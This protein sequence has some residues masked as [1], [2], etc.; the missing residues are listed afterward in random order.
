MLW[1]KA[2]RESRWRFLSGFMLLMLLACGIVLEY[3]ATAR[4]MPLASSIDPGDGFLGRAIKEALEAQRDFRG[5][6]WWQWVRQNLAVTWTLFALLLGSGGLLTEPGGRGPWFTLSLPAS[7]DRLLAVR[8]GAGLA[9]L[10]VLALVPSLLIPLMSPAIGETYPLRLAIVHGACLFVAGTAFFSL[11]L[12]LSTVFT[13]FWR[14]LLLAC[15]FAI[16]LGSVERVL[17]SPYGIFRVMSAEAYFR[18][19]QLPWAGLMTS[20][21]VSI[22]LLYGASI[23]FAQRDF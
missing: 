1:Y 3:P 11:T 18:S 2:W 6:V 14:P 19:G 12:L 8:V 21:A 20:A 15:V 22:A 16:G 7:R 10:L 17:W 9:E 23:N 4:L 13:D 5:F